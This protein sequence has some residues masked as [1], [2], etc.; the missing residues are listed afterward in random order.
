MAPTSRS[1]SL[2]QGTLAFGAAKR[3]ASASS[4][5]GKPATGAKTRAKGTDSAGSSAKA[6]PAPAPLRAFVGRK[7]A[8]SDDALV[9]SDSEDEHDED[10]V[11][12]ILKEDSGRETSRVQLA[13]ALVPSP[14]KRQRVRR[15]GSGVL[16]ESAPTLAP[17]AKAEAEVR[18]KL[19]VKD[20]RWRK[21][22]GAVREKMGN[23]EPGE[24]SISSSS[25]KIRY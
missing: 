24:F 16:S 12:E 15:T 7:R 10:D 19:N 4:I 25:P 8:L 20:T 9:P 17:A 14:A 13:P 6:S 22:Y 2:K 11:Q 21:H 3:T 18:P 1:A 23:V 5:G